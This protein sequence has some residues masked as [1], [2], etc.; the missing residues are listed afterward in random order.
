M[1]THAMKMID[2]S[3]SWSEII[4]IGGKPSCDTS[5]VFDREYLFRNPRPEE[6]DHDNEAEIMQ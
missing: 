1:K 3:T 6:A 4:R 5:R 2:K